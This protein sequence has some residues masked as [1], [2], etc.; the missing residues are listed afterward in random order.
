[1]SSSNGN[2]F[3]VIILTSFRHREHD[4]SLELGL[5]CMMYLDIV[6]YMLQRR[7]SSGE[8]LYFTRTYIDPA[9]QSV[10]DVNISKTLLSLCGYEALTSH[11]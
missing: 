2:E 11:S 9:I 3:E 1:M 5:K 7:E 4:I 10:G 6:R 8:K